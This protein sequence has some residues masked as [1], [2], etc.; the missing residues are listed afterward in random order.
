MKGMRQ[1]AIGGLSAAV[2]LV[3]AAVVHAGGVGQF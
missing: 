1:I 3:G 2:F